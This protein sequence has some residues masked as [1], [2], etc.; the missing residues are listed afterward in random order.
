[1][2]REIC[3][4]NEDEV[5]CAMLQA[6]D[7]CRAVV[8][9]SATRLHSSDGELEGTHPSPNFPARGLKS[10]RKN[11]IAFRVAIKKEAELTILSSP[12][13]PASCFA[14]SC[15]PSGLASST[16]IISQSKE[17]EYMS[18]KLRA[19]VRNGNA[20]LSECL[21]Q[22]PCNDGQVLPFVVGWKDDG[23]FECVRARAH[24]DG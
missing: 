11:R 5:P 16:M 24:V 10:Y 21:R 12:Y 20:L 14:T 4:H 6:M 9:V 2:M 19:S 7:V 22:Q 1:M 13:T 23:V 18:N 17:L 3:I 15:V 8:Y